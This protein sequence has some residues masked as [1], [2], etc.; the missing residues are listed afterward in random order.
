MTHHRLW[1]NESGSFDDHHGVTD[2]S[3]Q[4]P[5]FVKNNNV[6]RIVARI[7]RSQR[8]ARSATYVL[9]LIDRCTS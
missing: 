9:D 7:S 4:F 6:R 3:L 2:I 5:G 8:L 1:G